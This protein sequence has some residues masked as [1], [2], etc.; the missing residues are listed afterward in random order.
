MEAATLAQ[1]LSASS[2]ARA[3]SETYRVIAEE[4]SPGYVALARAQRHVQMVGRHL[5]R[6]VI[7][8]GVATIC[9][10][11]G[12][13]G[14][15]GEV[16]RLI[17]EI[18]GQTNLLA[19]NA[20][21]EAARAG[22]AG[23]GFAVVAGEVKVLATQT[24]RR[25][26]DISRQIALI[27]TATRDAVDAVRGI[28]D[29]VGAVDRVTG[30]IADAIGQQSAATEEIARAVAGAAASVRDV[31]A[32][33]ATVAEE[34]RRSGEEATAVRG[35]AD[36]AQASV[37]ELRQLL[38]RIV[39]SSTP[40]VDRRAA[41][42][43]PT[44]ER[45]NLS[46]GGGAAVAVELLDLSAIGAGLRAAPGILSPGAGVQLILDGIPVPGRVASADAE[47]RS[48]IR[49][50]ALSGAAAAV[51]AARLNGAQRRLAA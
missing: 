49:F 4:R 1:G 11:Q 7:K 22:E 48:G 47:G 17:S 21:I 24:A 40:E 42:R 10:L 25:T 26:E 45:V 51:V 18:A 29:G 3:L 16:A 50:E 30:A 5:N 19:L 38:V 32:R 12:V 9:G 23:K 8:A 39:R 27:E 20:T 31:E 43:V 37:A 46:V 13:V 28:A 33:I 36:A 41:D 34:A 6:M 2:S 44:A 35:A 15:I 14:R